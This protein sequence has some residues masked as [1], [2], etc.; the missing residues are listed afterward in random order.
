MASRVADYAAARRGSRTSRSGRRVRAGRR[1]L[2][3]WN[4]GSQRSRLEDQGRRVRRAGRPLGLRKID[5]FARLGWPRSRSRS[6][7]S[8]S[9]VATS[10]ISTRKPA[11]SPWCFR[12]MRS[13]RIR[14]FTKIS[15]IPCACRDAAR[16]YRPPGPPDRR[17]AGSDALFAAKT[18]G[19]F[20][21]SETAGRHGAGVGAQ[22]R[23]FPDGRTSPARHFSVYRHVLR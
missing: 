11:I 12:I 23:G 19:P 22:A 2:S 15:P 13:I 18:P 7:R 4:R 1:E 10:R 20:R 8:A 17:V 16:R 5:G 14:A 21:R 6:G 9:R 3:R